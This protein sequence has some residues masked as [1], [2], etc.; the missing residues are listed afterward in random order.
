[1]K[2]GGSIASDNKEGGKAP[3]VEISPL[4]S[5]AGEDLESQCKNVTFTPPVELKGD[6]AVT[7][8]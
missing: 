4:I 3:L 7:H 6:S 2:A 8:D 5:Y 1:M